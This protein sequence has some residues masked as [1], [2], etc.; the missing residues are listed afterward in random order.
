MTIRLGMLSP[1]LVSAI[2]FIAK[3]T[4]AYEKNGLT[5]SVEQGKTPPLVALQGGTAGSSTLVL[6][7]DWKGKSLDDLRTKPLKIAVSSPSSIH[8]ALFRGYLIERHIAAADLSWQ[9]LGME[10]G[11][12]APMLR[13]KQM[14]GFLHSEPATT[15][16]LNLGA[17]FVFMS[18]M[19]GDMGPTMKMIP[20]TLTSA[21]RAWVT[22]NR[23]TVKQFSAALNDANTSFATMPKAQ[24]VS[25]IAEWA[26]QPTDVVSQA[27]ERVDPRMNMTLAGAHA[28]WDVIGHA[29]QVR[30]EISN[31]LRFE[32]L[33]DT[34]YLLK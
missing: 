11:D 8:L 23:D 12:M 6:R 17:G 25:I 4:G 18:A 28:W 32:D 33:F 1:N 31:R 10:G 21:N 14:D 7:N 19:R 20:I 27:Y 30:G 3:K 26:R 16:A 5:L 2:H 13:A 29:I 15:I 34:N 22:N 9:F 24:M